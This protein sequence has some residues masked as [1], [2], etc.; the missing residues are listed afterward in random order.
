[1]E[2]VFFF[3]IAAGA[4]QT[5]RK[6]PVKTRWRF[7]P[8]R[9]RMQPGNKSLFYIRNSCLWRLWNRRQP[10]WPSILLPTPPYFQYGSLWVC[11]V[12]SFGP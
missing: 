6:K 2:S 12:L 7:H 9:V 11:W 10:P 5:P 3:H 1:M 4:E 8:R